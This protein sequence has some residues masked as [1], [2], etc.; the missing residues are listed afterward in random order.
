MGF[1]KYTVAL[2]SP[3]ESPSTVLLKLILHRA[4]WQIFKPTKSPV[5][6]V[7]YLKV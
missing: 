5:C 2:F 3:R 6:K 4:H 7:M 1:F